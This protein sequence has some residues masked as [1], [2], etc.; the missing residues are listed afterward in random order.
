MAEDK[1]KYV[2]TTTPKG[3][4]NYPWLNKPD[5]KF[6]PDGEFKCNLIVPAKQAKA[7]IKLIDEEAEKAI[8]EAKE[9]IIRKATKANAKKAKAEADKIKE[10]DKPYTEEVDEDG[11]PTGNIIFK[12]KQRA[13]IKTKKGD[14]FDKVIP[15]FDAEGTRI[16]AN[17]GGGSTLKLN[18]EL[19]YYYVPASKIAGVSLRLQAAQ[20]FELVEFGGSSADSFGFGTDEDGY[21]G[22]P[23]KPSK[24]NNK[25]KKASDE[26]EDDSDEDEEVY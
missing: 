5:T 22:E 1:Q 4:A 25:N 6:N 21:K 2:R 7:F 11:E 3:K 17:V 26:S 24:S 18:V 16:Q 14:E 23:Y 15:I 10:G 12:T 20:V 9:N 13:K 19:A 8:A